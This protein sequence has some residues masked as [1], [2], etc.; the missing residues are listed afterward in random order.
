MDILPA[1]GSLNF[2]ILEYKINLAL[3]QNQYPA[4]FLAKK[5]GAMERSLK[6]KTKG[7]V[8]NR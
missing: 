6:S 1:A 5:Y 8:V 7:G 3:V 2:Q 4:S